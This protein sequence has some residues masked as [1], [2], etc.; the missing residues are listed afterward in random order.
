MA[1]EDG[2]FFADAVRV[3]DRD[4]RLDVEIE[5]SGFSKKMARDLEGVVGFDQDAEV[6]EA[7]DDEEGQ[8]DS[9]SDVEVDEDGERQDLEMEEQL[10]ADEMGGLDVDDNL[11]VKPLRVAGWAI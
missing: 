2:P 6:Q 11:A 5:A 3:I 1:D 10:L 8:D 9:G 4:Q 7:D